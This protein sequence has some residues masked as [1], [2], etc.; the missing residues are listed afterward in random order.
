MDRKDFISMLSGVIM[1]PQIINSMSSQKVENYEFTTG[2]VDWESVRKD[3][4]LAENYVDLRSFAASALP[5]QTIE[6]YI[7]NYRDIQALPSVRN[8]GVATG[9][10]S[11]LRMKISEI[12]NCSFEEVAIMRNTTEALNTALMGIKLNEGD[13]VLASVHE[14]DSMVSTLVQR[15]KREG[16][17]VTNVDIPYKPSS[18]E[19]I[20]ECF[21]KSVTPKTKLI[22]ISHIVWISGQIYPIKEICKWARENNIITV[23]DA[24]QSFSHIDIDVLKID[25]DY[26]GASLHKWCAAPLG[27]GF[28][29]VKKDNIA[30]TYPLIASYEYSADSDRIEKFENFG[31]ITPVFN[32]CLNSID[33]W[34]NLGHNKKTQRIQFLKNY[35]SERLNGLKGVEIATNLEPDQSCGILYFTVK[36]KSAI[37]LRNRL[38]SE[39]NISVQAIENY[40]NMYVDYKGVNC[41]GV[42]TPV[43]ILEKQLDYFIDSLTN[44]I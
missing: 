20:L 6:H 36:G 16:I 4:F 7:K 13:E 15:Q 38:Y 25:C 5:K 28:L 34:M 43:Y 22:L 3:F 2:E 9:E 10:K 27:T 11:I 18:K 29:Y 30:D 24:A 37:E 26:L 32:S 12:L 42:S 44:I 19:Q 17:V 40:K 33:Y 31:S 21:K 35:L 8:H 39:Y 14:Y 23:I 41:I 1:M